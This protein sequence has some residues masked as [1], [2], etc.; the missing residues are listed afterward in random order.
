M[1]SLY[2]E[3]LTGYIKARGLTLREI[4]LRC[5]ARGQKIAPSYISKLQN[6]YL[7]PPSEIVSVTLAEVLGCNPNILVYRG[8]LEK[9]P[10]SIRKILPKNYELISDDVLSFIERMMVL[11]PVYQNKLIDELEWLEKMQ[12]RDLKYSAVS[13]TVSL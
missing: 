9:A 7:P 10:D 2:K 11:S 12:Q 1:E 4:S 8:Y 13:K 5:K 3:L 6:G